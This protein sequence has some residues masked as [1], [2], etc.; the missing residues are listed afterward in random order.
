MDLTVDTQGRSRFTEF[1][2]FVVLKRVYL[3]SHN[4]R[5]ALDQLA[6]LLVSAISG[7]TAHF[8]RCSK[9]RRLGRNRRLG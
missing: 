8:W 6:M 3:F 9:F 1:Q 4:S 7:C 2:N 5:A